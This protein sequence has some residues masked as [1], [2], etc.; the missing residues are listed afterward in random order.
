M[1]YGWYKRYVIRLSFHLLGRSRP[2]G[3]CIA[4]QQRQVSAKPTD[5]GWSI[6]CNDINK[7]I[8]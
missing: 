5:N 3:G 1:T 6:I 8:I 4:R 7:V 2:V